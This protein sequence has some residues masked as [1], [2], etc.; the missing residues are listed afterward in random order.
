MKCH[1][2]NDEML[3]MWLQWSTKIKRS[4]IVYNCWFMRKGCKWVLQT[5]HRLYR[6]VGP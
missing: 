3:E 5:G 6:I 4:Q 1:R 2:F